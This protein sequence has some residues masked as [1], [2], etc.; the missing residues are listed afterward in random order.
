[1]Y[2]FFRAVDFLT[3]CNRNDILLRSHKEIQQFLANSKGVCLDHFKEIEAQESND[4]E[5]I[6]NAIGKPQGKFAY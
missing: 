3:L 2:F 6:N 5:F 4:G 1:M